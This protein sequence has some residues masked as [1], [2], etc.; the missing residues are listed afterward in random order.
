MLTKELGVEAGVEVAKEVATELAVLALTTVVASMRIICETMFAL[1]IV[2]V[3]LL[4]LVLL[5]EPVDPLEAVTVG[6][7]V[8][9]PLPILLALPI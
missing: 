5:L 4:L 1:V 2:V 3:T 8:V 9:V 7:A 6:G